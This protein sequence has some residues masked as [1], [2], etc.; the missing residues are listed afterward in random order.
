VQRTKIVDVRR[1]EAVDMHGLSGSTTRRRMIQGEFFVGAAGCL[2]L[3]ILT[4][5]AT[6]RWGRVL[7][8]WLIGI[9]VNYVP[10]AIHAVRLSHPGALEKELE[11]V[12]LRSEARRVGIGQLLDPLPVRPRRVRRSRTARLRRIRRYGADSSIRFSRA[13]SACTRSAS[14]ANS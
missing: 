5:L 1:L 10:L 14:R 11:G 6:E 8:P 9:G 3:G 12:N 7:G 13:R 4:S 2:S